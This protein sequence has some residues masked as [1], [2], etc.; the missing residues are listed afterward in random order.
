MKAEMLLLLPS[1]GRTFAISD[2][3]SDLNR[4]G[5]AGWGVGMVNMQERGSGWVDGMCVCEGGGLTAV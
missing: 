5:V 2:V 3:S 1:E 4:I